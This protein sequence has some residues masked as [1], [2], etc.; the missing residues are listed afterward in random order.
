[1]SEASSRPSKGDVVHI[2]DLNGFARVTDFG[3]DV[4]GREVW[5]LQFLGGRC[6]W[7]LP[8]IVMH[9]PALARRPLCHLSIEAGH[10]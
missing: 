2:G 1:M 7:A 5:F 4:A 8:S 3:Q 9:G 6:G 10:T